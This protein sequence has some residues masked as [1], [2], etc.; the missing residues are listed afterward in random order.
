MERT[1]R[2]VVSKESDSDQENRELAPGAN[3]VLKA[4]IPR[5]VLARL[6]DIA[7]KPTS[8]SP[9]LL[10]GNPA[11]LYSF[12]LA[13]LYASDFIELPKGD[14]IKL[15][16]TFLKIA[17]VLLNP[18]TNLTFRIWGD[19]DMCAEAN[20]QFPGHII[21]GS[22]VILNQVDTR[23]RIS[24][25]VDQSDI[26]KL[27]WPLIPPD[28]EQEINFDFEGHFKLPVIA[29]LFGFIDLARRKAKGGTAQAGND[30]MTSSLQQV[31]D[32]LSNQWGLTGFEDFIT[33]ITVAGMNYNPPSLSQILESLIL[34][35]DAKVL[36]KE[37][38]DNYTLAP[39]FVPLVTRTIGDQAGLQWQR[40]TQ[41]PSGELLWSHRIYVF[42]DS[43][44]I[45]QFAPTVEG[46][47]FVSKVTPKQITDFLIEEVTLPPLIV[48]VKPEIPEASVA[49]PGASSGT[50]EPTTPIARVDTQC[51]F[52][53][54]KNSQ[55]AV[56][57]K[58][59]GHLLADNQSPRSSPAPAVSV[60]QLATTQK[61]L[62]ALQQEM[63]SHKLELS[64]LEI[65]YKVGEISLNQYQ[66]SVSTLQAK[67][68]KLETTL[69]GL[70]KQ[71]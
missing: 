13:E 34:L 6:L 57:C 20:V 31:N 29:V 35:T 64:K 5:S 12:Q 9:R 14:S 47:V 30:I 22:G 4:D 21:D 65:R 49:R 39:V 42:T 2:K 8:I 1:K 54:K 68:K 50:R 46:K 24:A 69:E 15:S 10:M 53:G 33:Y 38:G 67:I 11:E 26:F 28:S 56:T 18:Q 48:S 16:P 59:C 44:L 40:V 36:I 19:L 66:D 7:G 51:R 43:S 32:Y 37:K 62:L 17:R 45:L 3:L 61:Q 23:Y 71:I 52:C 27:I 58:S 63:K 41:L 60:E 70:A 55:E 25:F